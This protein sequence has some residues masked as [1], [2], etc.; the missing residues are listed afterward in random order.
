VAHAA[1]LGPLCRAAQR[2]GYSS[3][4]SNQLLLRKIIVPFTFHS[5][6]PPKRALLSVLTASSLV[7]A[8]PGLQRRACGGAGTATGAVRILERTR[9]WPSGKTSKQGKSKA[10]VKVDAGV[11]TTP[12][13][14]S[15]REPQR[16]T[17]RAR[18]RSAARS[19]RARGAA[20][21]A[22]LNRSEMVHDKPE[23]AR[24]RSKPMGNRADLTTT[25]VSGGEPASTKRAQLIGMLERPEGASVAEIGQR[26]GWLPHTVRA[27]ITG[28]RKAGREVMRSNDSNDRSVY[29]LV[30][31]KTAG[32]R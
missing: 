32:E 2:T 10:E 9:P 24:S 3:V 7:A 23:Q 22:R 31:V 19:D 30:T 20:P 8:P 17:P 14:K 15:E 16:R 4:T 6:S 25:G 29:R 12:L 13:A 26:L 11:A 5:T 21:K 28:L 27:A 18:S 1:T